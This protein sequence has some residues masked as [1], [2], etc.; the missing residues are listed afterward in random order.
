MEKYYKII[1]AKTEYRE[2]LYDINDF[3]NRNDFNFTFKKKQNIKNDVSVVIRPLIAEVEIPAGEEVIEC[4]Y[5][6]YKANKI[7]LKN[8]KSIFDDEVLNEFQD[9][10]EFL[11]E[12]FLAAVLESNA[13][14][15]KQLNTDKHA[16]VKGDISNVKKIIEKGVKVT[17]LD[18]EGFDSA[19]YVGNLNLIKY[20]IEQGV[21]SFSWNSAAE[22]GSLEVVQYF[23]EQNPDTLEKLPSSALLKICKSGY[24]EIAMYL[25]EKGAK[26]ESN[27]HEAH[28][29]FVEAVSH[30]YLNVVK[31]IYEQGIDMYGDDF[32]HAVLIAAENGDFEIVKFLIEKGNEH[33]HDCKT[34]ALIGAIRTGNIDMIHYLIEL[35]TDIHAKEER[36]L[37]EAAANNKIEIVKYLVDLGADYKNQSVINVAAEK[38]H[39]EI[40][41]YLIDLGVDIH[42]NNE[43]VL[44][45]A[46]ENGHFD[47]VKY[48]I[49][50]GVDINAN[51]SKALTAAI[52][53]G[54]AEATRYLFDHGATLCINDHL[55]LNQA[56]RD[57]DCV[58]LLLDLTDSDPLKKRLIITAA[59][60]GCLS[61]IDYLREKGF[62]IDNV[63]NEALL[64]ATRERNWRSVQYLLE[65]GADIHI[66]NDLIFRT[67]ADTT[68]I[69][70]IDM[71]LNKGA[72]IHAKNDYILRTA[73]N[74]RAKEVVE[75]LLSKGA[76]VHANDDDALR[77][78][79]SLG[80]IDLVKC[81]VRYGANIHAQNDALNKAIKYG[82]DDVVAYLLEQ[83]ADSVE[84]E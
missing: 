30:G 49:E 6:V 62:D 2:G 24:S 81:L 4:E 10:K 76:D 11:E 68:D 5:D 82:R 65:N 50:K 46:A 42:A 69:E 14:C 70:K 7:I 12:A 48:L 23:V 20:L 17:D 75:F 56:V 40:I 78:A 31:W 3:K 36:A 13:D 8:I 83:G 33:H 9:D 67:F 27:D 74:R 35:G 22:S 34:W 47:I 79:A 55:Y 77:D 32:D 58:K 64:L 60:E 80:D 43:C 71:L 45:S 25:I 44:S 18:D 29:A 16:F 39:I 28:R 57:L 63:K 38:G 41:K 1:S 72:D 61:V 84:S 66:E 15:V 59:K 52:N 21:N 51:D 26:L 53:Y 19:C 54:N 73:V 37:Y